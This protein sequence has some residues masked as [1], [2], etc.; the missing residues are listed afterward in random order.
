M[1][2]SNGTD[3]ALTLFRKTFTLTYKNLNCYFFLCESHMHY[4]SEKCV[5]GLWLVAAAL[6]TNT[7]KTLVKQNARRV[8]IAIQST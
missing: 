4:G 2:L 8:L 6:Y 7:K 5:S 1:F 3:L